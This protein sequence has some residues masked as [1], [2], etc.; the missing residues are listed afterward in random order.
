M[1]IPQA[2]ITS[3]LF[4]LCCL[5][6]VSLGVGAVTGGLGANPTE[7][8]IRELGQWGLR[9]LLIT[10]M[11]TPVRRWL[12]WG[13]LLAYRRMIGLFAFFYVLLH[14]FGF[15]WFDHFFDWQAVLADIVKRPFITL[16]MVALLLLIPLALTSTRRAVLKLGYRRWQQLHR[17]L[18]VAVSLALV[19]FFLLVKADLLEPFVYLV[20]W[21]ALICL[22]LSD[23]F[24][25]GWR[26][27]VNE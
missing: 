23:G 15:I 24:F 26:K 27:P 4:L 19:H 25:K 3:L 12:G 8:L 2:L 5:P 17:L 21:I 16:G 9:L 10:L 11:A 20:V 1:K 13:L 6:L 22:R 14:L 7:T 18:Y